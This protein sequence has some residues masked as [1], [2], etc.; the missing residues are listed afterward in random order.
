MQP[1]VKSTFRFCIVALLATYMSVSSAAETI[2]F[3]GDQWVIGAIQE[4]DL[5]DGV[6]VI[7][8]RRYR[9]SQGALRD[10][11]SGEVFNF[12]MPGREVVFR[13]LGSGAISE[14]RELAH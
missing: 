5:A 6:V 7:N 14:I 12:L 13:E 4:V 11:E 2:V 1:T 9:L 10:N 3:E 8:D